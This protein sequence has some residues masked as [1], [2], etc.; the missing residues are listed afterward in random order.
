MAAINKVLFVY[1]SRVQGF[2][3]WIIVGGEIA[4]IDNKLEH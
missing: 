2:A 4:T 3:G 1:D